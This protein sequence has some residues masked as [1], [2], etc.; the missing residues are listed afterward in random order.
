MKFRK[1]LLFLFAS[2]FFVSA[3]AED[4]ELIFS[5]DKGNTAKSYWG[6][7]KRE[8]Y[9]VAIALNQ[10]TFE[11]TLIKS[12]E[13]PVR[14]VEKMTDV[15]LWITSVLN[16]NNVKGDI[17]SYLIDLGKDY[18]ASTGLVTHKLPEPVRISGSKDIYIGYTF[19][20]SSLNQESKEPL[21]VVPGNK[22]ETFVRTASLSNVG[23]WKDLGLLHGLSSGIRV[24]LGDA[25]KYSS[26]F[27]PLNTLYVKSRDEN[28]IQAYVTNHGS[29]KISNIS[30]T[31]TVAGSKF[32]GTINFDNPVSNIY[33]AYG[34]AQIDLPVIDSN[35]DY[36][37]ELEVKEI[38]GIPNTDNTSVRTDM[39]VFSILPIKRPFTEEYTASSCGYCPKGMAMMEIMKERKGKDFIAV[40]FHTWNDPLD[41]YRDMPI[42]LTGSFSLPVAQIDRINKIDPYLG[43]NQDSFGF[44]ICWDEAASKFSTVEIGLEGS[45]DGIMA[46]L[47][48][49]TVFVYPVKSEEYR[50]EFFVV[51]DGLSIPG[52]SQRNYYSKNESARGLLG[53]ERFVDEP[54]Y[55]M[56][57]AYD[58]AVVA[59]SGLAGVNVP[60]AQEYQQ[61]SLPFSIEIPEVARKATLRGVAAVVDN[62][63]G[64]VVNAN[65]VSLGAAAVNNVTVERL[66]VETIYY[67][68]QGIPVT[69]PDGICIRKVVYTDGSY[70]TIKIIKRK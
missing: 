50:V 63:T 49:N 54:A 32:S 61:V 13:I 34:E 33:G 43:N 27:A 19:T 37:L 38:N 21:T 46:N 20:L 6:T 29:E 48:A 31:G 39:K 67:T 10:S 23:K 7:S 4:S 58:D 28:T 41:F 56:D 24:I 12:I 60:A 3:F 36:T 25:D 5:F 59:W 30:Y 26:C 69:E 57:F 66:P 14:G 55:I 47:N 53:I 18:D 8:K 65:Q 40:A 64:E 42:N 1:I 68:L 62:I 52:C 22:G 2:I 16:E 35:G 11:G 45:F 70:D 17:Y 51:A 9:D 44:D 15:K